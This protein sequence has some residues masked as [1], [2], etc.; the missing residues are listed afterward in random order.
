[1]RVW[2]LAVGIAVAAYPV[3]ALRVLW[4]ISPDGRFVCGTVNGQVQFLC[5][6]RFSLRTPLA[7]AVRLYRHANAAFDTGY[8]MVCLWCGARSGVPDSVP[9]I[10]AD[11]RRAGPLL[12]VVLDDFTD[13]ALTLVCQACGNTLRLNAFVVDSRG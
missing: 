12:G 2:D 10:T 9:L 6:E 8:A 1:M 11:S 3:R 7:T 5:L 13:P 4:A